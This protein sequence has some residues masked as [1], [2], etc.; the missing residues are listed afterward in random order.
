MTAAITHRRVRVNDIDIHLAEAGDGSPE[1]WYSW[2]HQLPVVA[3]AGYHGMAPD[4]CGYGQ[5]T[6][7]TRSR[8]M[9]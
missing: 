5:T 8:S 6:A 1:L 4:L 3:E 7:L 2:R 9:R